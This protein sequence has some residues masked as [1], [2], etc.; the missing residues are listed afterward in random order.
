MLKARYEKRGPVPQD[1]IE[2]VSVDAPELGEGEVLV[3]VLAA[4]INPSDVLTLTGDYGTLPPL[5]AIGGNEGVG[6]VAELGPNASGVEKGQTV[7]LPVGAGTWSTHVT[8]AAKDLIPLPGEADPKQLSM[9]TINPPTA[10]LLLEQF[11]DLK[12]GDWVIQNAANSGVGGYLMQIAAQRGIRTVN[13]VRRES[14]VAGVEEQG[15]DVTLVDGPDLH[16]RVKEATGG[17]AI[18][19]GIDAVGGQSTDHIASCLTEGAPVVN[20]GMMSGEPCQMSPANVVFR[21]VSLKGFW[22]ARWFS[23]ASKEDQMKI[24]GQ[25]TQQIASGKLKAKIAAEYDV[26]QIK[27]AVAAA[28]SGERDGKILVVPQH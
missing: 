3:E 15:G 23:K 2:A 28:A 1:V 19:L 4:P 24:Y 7:L 13:V 12:E 25:V 21:D 22:L 16:K 5:P 8:A 14:A 18:K 20:Y 10:I 17:A 6:R 11:V 9:M 26:S 27:D